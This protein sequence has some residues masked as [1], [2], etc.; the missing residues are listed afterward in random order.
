V[1]KQYFIQTPN[2]WFPIEPHFV[3]PAFHWLPVGIRAWLVT[4]FALGW[5]EKFTDIK[6]AKAE[7]QS[8]RLLTKREFTGL[9]PGLELSEEKF[10]GLTKSFTVYSKVND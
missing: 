2:F 1:G 6:Q 7:V 8:I 10:W 3:F 9:F 5:Y 4:H